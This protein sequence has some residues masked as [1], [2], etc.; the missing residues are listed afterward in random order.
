MSK[1]RRMSGTMAASPTTSTSANFKSR[2]LFW[3]PMPQV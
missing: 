1:R 3:T 2:N